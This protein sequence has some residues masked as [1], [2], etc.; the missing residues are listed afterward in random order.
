MTKN[1]KGSNIPTKLVFI[2]TTM[3][4]KRKPQ[5]SFRVSQRQQ[6]KQKNLIPRKGAILTLM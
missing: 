4:D 2:T 5:K 3:C 6:N 1:G